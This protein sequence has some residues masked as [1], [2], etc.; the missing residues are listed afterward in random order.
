MSHCLVDSSAVFNF[1]PRTTAEFCE[2]IRTSDYAIT[3]R[4][5]DSFFL[6]GL[7]I[8]NRKARKWCGRRPG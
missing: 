5:I 4:L 6:P 3:E 8:R 1:I 2:A 7:A